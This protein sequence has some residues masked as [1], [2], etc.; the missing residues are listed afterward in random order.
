MTNA[1]ESSDLRRQL[2]TVPGGLA[3][4]LH[5]IL[6]ESPLN[7]T[8]LAS[9]MRDF[10]V[11]A[12]PP[13]ISKI[14]AG[15]QLPSSEDIRAWCAACGR[16]EL[17]PE[18]ARLAG[19]VR[20]QHRVWRARLRTEGGQAAVQAEFQ[21][22][23][24]RT[25]LTRNFET[26]LFPG[27][28]Q[29]RPMAQAVMRQILIPLGR[30]EED[31]T[32]GVDGRLRRQQWLHDETKRFEFILDESMLVR[33]LFG[34]D[35]TI[36]QVDRLHSLIGLSNVR[37]GILPM[38]RPLNVTPLNGFILFDDVALVETL[39]GETKHEG[40]EAA[41]Y[42]KV[43]DRLW[44]DAIEGE[45]ARPRLVRAVEVLRGFREASE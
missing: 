20:S 23:D 11:K 36:G 15:K 38:D 6:E 27:L 3:D 5:Q 39:V 16:P 19:E 12:E 8:E 28:V 33:P 4:R 17:E 14:L 31:V 22:L 9:K 41:E 40:E 35:I 43:M 7:N 2:L 18:L 34:V 37:L 26:A 44:E 10:G 30:T 25:T 29:T 1:D 13:K 24:A 42:H 32:H 21:S 45:A